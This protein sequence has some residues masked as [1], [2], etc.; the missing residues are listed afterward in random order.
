[1]MMIKFGMGRATVDASQEIRDNKITREEGVN[2][3]NKYDL[4]FP[5]KYFDD[6]L[7]YT[8]INAETFHKTVD[9]YR[10]EHLWIKKSNYWELRN[11][12]E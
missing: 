6:F 10:S 7:N 8:T 5:E 12:L 11:K 9:S 4:E 2:L 1:M 3:V